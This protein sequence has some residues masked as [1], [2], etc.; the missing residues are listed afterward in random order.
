MIASK[1]TVPVA[2]VALTVVFSVVCWI[3]P[4]PNTTL[5]IPFGFKF[6]SML[7]SP[8]LALITGALPVAAFPTK[9]SFTAE[10]VVWNK[11]CSLSFWSLIE[12]LLSIKMLF[13]FASKSPPNWGVVLYLNQLYQ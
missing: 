10:A 11:I 8:P 1:F 2:A 4:A 6:K 13:P 5:P 12:L 9:I 7:V 3:E